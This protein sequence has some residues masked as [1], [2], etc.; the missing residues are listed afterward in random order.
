MIEKKAAKA[1][2]VPMKINGVPPVLKHG[3]GMKKWAAEESC[4]IMR[5]NSKKDS[6][7]TSRG[8]GKADEI[9][10]KKGDGAGNAWGAAIVTRSAFEAADVPAVASSANMRTRGSVRTGTSGGT[11]SAKIGNAADSCARMRITSSV[12]DAAV[13][14]MKHRSRG[15]SR[16]A[17]AIVRGVLPVRANT[18]SGKDGIPIA[19]PL[20]E[21]AAVRFAV[22]KEPVVA[23]SPFNPKNPLVLRQDVKAAKARSRHAKPLNEFLMDGAS[24]AAAVPKT[25][26]ADKVAA[27]HPC[28]EGK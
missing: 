27:G 22:L 11:K 23:P 20:P 19:R 8:I 24:K 7:K 16:T 14:E 6:V 9:T 5:K 17:S 1:R 28:T 4:R 21:G 10:K 25:N 12:T 18:A 2:N 15:M 26:A 3:T 13:G